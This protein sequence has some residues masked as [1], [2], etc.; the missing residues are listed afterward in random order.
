MIVSFAYSWKMT[1][2]VLVWSPFVLGASYYESKLQQGFQD[3]TVQA[4]KDC[5]QVASEAIKEI[6]TVAALGKQSY[7]GDRYAKAME[8][9]HRLAKRKAYLS[10]ISFAVMQSIALYAGGVSFYAGTNFIGQGME[11][12]AL[13]ICLMCVLITLQSAG[14][15][16]TFVSTVMRAKVSA[17]TIFGVLERKT[18]IDPDLEGYEIESSRISGTFRLETL[19]SDTLQDRI[20]LYSRAGSTCTDTADKLLHSWDHP[21]VASRPVSACSNDGTIRFR[22]QCVSITKMSRDSLCITCGATWHWL[23]KSLSCLM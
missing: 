1:F 21:D 15:A 10:S 9:P 11:F 5:G 8:R 6:R 12:Q 19:R 7:F 17:I 3:K 14:Q 16:S 20:F 2:I 13:F 4:N 23:A 22:V 18:A